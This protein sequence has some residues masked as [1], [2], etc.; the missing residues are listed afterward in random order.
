[1]FNFFRKALIEENTRLKEE[2][3]C[4]GELNSIKQKEINKLNK[5]IREKD[6]E[7]K[8][9]RYILKSENSFRK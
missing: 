4:L 2:K 6:K 8:K 1:M 9:L 5:K 3:K 7:L